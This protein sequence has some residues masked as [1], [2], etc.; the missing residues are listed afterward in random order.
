MK[1]VKVKNIRQLEKALGVQLPDEVKRDIRQAIKFYRRFH[2]SDPKEIEYTDLHIPNA[3][4]KLG[5]VLSILYIAEKDGG[6]DIYAHAFQPPLPLYAGSDG[7]L[8]ITG[9]FFVEKEGI[10]K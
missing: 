4:T 2:Q 5:D 9:E 1:T 8:V 6:T 7:L 3:L 10:L